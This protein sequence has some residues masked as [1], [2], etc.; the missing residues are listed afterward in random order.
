MWPLITNDHD[1]NLSPAELFTAYHWQ[2]NLEKRHAQLKGTQ[3][4]AAGDRLYAA[5]VDLLWRT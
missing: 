4:Y 3:S 5:P 2:P 1:H